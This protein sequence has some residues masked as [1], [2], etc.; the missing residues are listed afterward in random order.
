MTPDEPDPVQAAERRTDRRV[1][2]FVTASGGAVFG[3]SMVQILGGEPVSAALGA[4]VG[5][6]AYRN[7]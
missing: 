1:D 3:A 4:T 6:L 5:Y 7:R 2:A